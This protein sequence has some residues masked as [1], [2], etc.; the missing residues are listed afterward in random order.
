MCGSGV[1][2]LRFPGLF[3]FGVGWVSLDFVLCKGLV[4]LGKV[5]VR[6]VLSGLTASRLG[7]GPQ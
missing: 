7:R 6:R 4:G 5:P 1:C 2:G 3:L